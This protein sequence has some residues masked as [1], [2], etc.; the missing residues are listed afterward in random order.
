MKNMYVEIL[1]KFK[2]KSEL[3]KYTTDVLNLLVTDK[4]VDYICLAETG[5]VIYTCE[6]GMIIWNVEHITIC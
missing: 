2:N 1:V 6:E 5:E 4:D 3:C